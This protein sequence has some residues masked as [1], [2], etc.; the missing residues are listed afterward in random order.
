[1]LKAIQ[2]D[3]KN[4]RENELRQLQKELRSAREA[5]LAKDGELKAV[6]MKLDEAANQLKEASEASKANAQ[7]SHDA[8]VR[9]AQGSRQAISIEEKKL[10]STEQELAIEEEKLQNTQHELA[11]AR[12]SM[13]AMKKELEQVTASFKA[14]QQALRLTRA[15][16]ASDDLEIKRSR[17]VIMKEEQ[18]MEHFAKTHAQMFSD[19]DGSTDGKDRTSHLIT[20]NST[21]SVEGTD[22]KDADRY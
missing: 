17:E 6:H 22:S 1:M 3:S 12:V 2:H 21:E 8:Y 7:K 11:A 18:D 16:L 19:V 15:K 5:T 13:S 4:H 14:A 9:L 20:S 10:H